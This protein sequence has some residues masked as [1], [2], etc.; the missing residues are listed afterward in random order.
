VLEPLLGELFVRPKMT[1][2]S[3]LLQ[4][5]ERISLS[6]LSRTFQDAIRITQQLQKRYLW[7]DSLCIIPDDPQDWEAEAAK[8]PAIYGSVTLTIAA[9]DA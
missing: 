6:E 2:K 4:H 8:M 1:R 7:I 3:T 5:M 9:S